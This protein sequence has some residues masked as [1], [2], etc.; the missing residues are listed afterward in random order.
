LVE[1][2]GLHVVSTLRLAEPVQPVAQSPRRGG[3]CFDCRPMRRVGRSSVRI[4]SIALG[5]FHLSR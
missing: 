5:P 4:A 2:I 1:A 3:I